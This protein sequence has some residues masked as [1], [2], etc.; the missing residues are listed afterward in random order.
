MITVG[1]LGAVAAGDASSEAGPPVLK[2]VVDLKEK[3][4][5]LFFG[6]CILA[7]FGIFQGPAVK[8]SSIC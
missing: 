1:T 6:D 4:S 2:V 7:R 5:E 8:I 3:Y